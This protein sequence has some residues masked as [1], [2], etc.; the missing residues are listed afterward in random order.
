MG[1]VYIQDNTYNYIIIFITILLAYGL[2]K[3]FNM[4]NNLDTKINKKIDDLYVD[5]DENEENQGP[6]DL[7]EKKYEEIITD[8]G[9]SG[10]TLEEK[11]EEFNNKKL[12][13]I[14]EIE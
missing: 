11:I 6:I 13:A 14:D 9:P 3:I 12:D 5:F 7:N 2:Y 8:P 1:K 10:V 4:I